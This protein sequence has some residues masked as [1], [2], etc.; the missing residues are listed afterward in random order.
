MGRCQKRFRG[1]SFEAEW[2]NAPFASFTR[3][4]T[5]PDFPYR[6]VIS[7]INPD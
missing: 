6:G 2:L 1:L 4:T 5:G 7:L 3:K